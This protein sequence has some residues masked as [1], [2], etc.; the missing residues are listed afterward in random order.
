MTPNQGGATNWPPPSF[1]PATGLFYVS[2]SRAFSIFYLYDIGDNPMG[3]GGT[4]RGGYSE[5]M[6]QAID[7]KTGKVRWSHKWENNIR[8]GLLST[9]GNLLF[10]GGPSQDIVALNATTGDALWHARLNAA[11]S[12]GPISYE[13]DGLQYLI[14]GAGDTLW[15]FVMNSN[16][17]RF[18]VRGSGFEGFGVHWFRVPREHRPLMH[19][20]LTHA[21]HIWNPEPRTYEP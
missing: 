5:S 6:I 19:T 8:S 21:T 4:D 18:R 10:A 11:V 7:Y 1:S 3:W 2:A 14:V 13:I 20:S 15:A 16:K 9:A 12:N 17:Q